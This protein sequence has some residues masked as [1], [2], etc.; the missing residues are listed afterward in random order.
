MAREGGEGDAAGDTRAGV[1]RLRRGVELRGEETDEE[2]VE[3]A[4]R[5][6]VRKALASAIMRVEDAP[7]HWAA[8][9]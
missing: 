3:N 1:R 5:I 8:F 2:L 9:Y 4:K 6:G 7:G